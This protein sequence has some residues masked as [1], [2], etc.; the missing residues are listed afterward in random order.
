MFIQKKNRLAVYSYL[1][2]E[3]VLV[4]KKDFFKPKHDKIEDVPNLEVLALMKSMKSRGLVRETFNWQY[5]Y[6]YLTAEGIEYLR[7]YLHLPEEIV[8]ATL[9]KSASRPARPGPAP[10][11]EREGGRGG[12]YGGDRDETEIGVVF[13]ALGPS[14]HRSEKSF[15]GVCRGFLRRVY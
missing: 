5:F 14:A 2:K 3:G 9:K 10:G 12:G 6:W 11:G 15:F 7:E 4:A 1:F 8:P 13:E